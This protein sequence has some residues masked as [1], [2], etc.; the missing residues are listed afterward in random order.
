MA[1]KATSVYLTVT[2]SDH[3]TVFHKQFFNA[4]EYNTFIATD[5]FVAKYPTTEFRIIKEVY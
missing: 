3:K 1:R 4:K 5:E 2:T